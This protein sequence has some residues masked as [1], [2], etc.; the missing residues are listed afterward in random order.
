MFGELGRGV[1]ELRLRQRLLRS[2]V[3]PSAGRNSEVRGESMGQSEDARDFGEVL[4]HELNN[5][6]TGILEN[7][8]LLLVEVHWHRIELPPNGETRRQRN[9]ALAVRM[10]ETIRKLSEE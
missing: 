10:R 1:V 3:G 6:L 4:R 2:N 9:A 8:E 5:P 7:A